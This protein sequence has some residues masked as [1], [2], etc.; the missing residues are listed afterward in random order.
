MKIFS[1]SVLLSIFILL[2]S[3]ALYFVFVNSKPEAHSK[4]NITE[5]PLVETFVLESKYYS[6]N[7]DSFGEIVTTKE[8]DIK[9]TYSGKIYEVGNVS[10]GSLIKKGDLLFRID[11][12][13]IEN[14]IKQIEAEKKIISSNID[15]FTKQISSKNLY[16]KEVENQKNIL[17]KQLK[18]KLNIAGNVISENALDEIRLSLSRLDETLI[19]IKEL[20]DILHIDLETNKIKLN[21]LNIVL[22]RH[23]NDLEKTYVRAP[24]SGHIQNIKMYEG[25]E[26]FKNEILGKLKDTKNLEV[27]FFIGGEDYNNLLKFENRGIDKVIK[28]KWL[29]GKKEYVSEAIITRLDGEINQDTAGINLYAKLVNNNNEIPI[30]AFVEINMKRILN[31]KTIKIPNSAVFNNKYIY[32]LEGKYL[33]RK[34][35]NIISE[36]SDGLLVEDI[37]LKGKLIVVTRLSEMQDNMQVQSLEGSY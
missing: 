32:L 22:K 5:F 3:L 37:D 19:N 4:K 6:S 36:E 16:I 15:K 24:F 18:N 20:I 11:T 30:G 34:K 21:K 33:K 28:V 13:D 23:K 35:I 1:K 9:Y 12:F 26:I 8:I 7:I 31:F 29:V 17:S 25:Q 10:D 2:A 14:E 27:K